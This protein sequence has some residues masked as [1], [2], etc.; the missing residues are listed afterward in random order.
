MISKEKLLDLRRRVHHHT[1]CNEMAVVVL[2]AKELQELLEEIEILNQ[3]N[4]AHVKTLEALNTAP[5]CPRCGS[6]ECDAAK[7]WSNHC[8]S[9]DKR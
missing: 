3:V 9:D 2:T 5:K 7:D 6:T 4:D 1:D 8:P